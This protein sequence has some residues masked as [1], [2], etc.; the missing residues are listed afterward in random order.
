[1]SGRHIRHADF[2]SETVKPRHIDVWTPPDYDDSSDRY[3]V[4]YMHDGQNLFHADLSFSGVPW[5]VDQ[6]AARM[7]ELGQIR[8][9]IIVGIWNTDQRVPEYMPQKPLRAA[10]TL[11][12]KRFE[13][14]YGGPAVSDAYLRFMV[15]ELKPFIDATYRTLPE[16][17][18][19]FVMG[20]SMGGLI[21]L[22]ALCEYPHVF[23]GAA[24]LSTSWTV[25]GGVFIP[26]LRRAI[27]S[28]DAHNVYF[29]YG[30]EARIAT[31]EY[32]QK[33]VN[34]LFRSA[35]YRNNRS[36][37]SRRFPG[38]DHSEQAWHDRIDEPLLFL[39]GRV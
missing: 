38:A 27:P 12:S 25:A 16:Q 20:S 24:C 32:Y 9:P 33:Q 14:R 39:L 36:W 29:D 7:A 30:S 31:Y 4:I 6:T 28:P 17:P 18:H 5:G 3:P 34:K 10:P 35:G 21:S 37:T 22:Y 11:V 26:Y 2:S 8:M 23:S 19:T 1:M 13:K 15:D